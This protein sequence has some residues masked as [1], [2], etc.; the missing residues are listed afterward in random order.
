MLK[1]IPQPQYQSGSF[2]PKAL[3]TSGSITTVGAVSGKYVKYG[4]LVSVSLSVNIVNNGTGAGYLKID[5][6]PF[7]C[8]S[9]DGNGSGR[10]SSFTGNGL[11]GRIDAG[12]KNLYIQTYAGLYPAGSGYTVNFTV[13]YLTSS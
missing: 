12:T 1:L 4:N 8:G 6:M 2:S 7:A 5:N 3:P 9:V 13:N 11:L 10:E